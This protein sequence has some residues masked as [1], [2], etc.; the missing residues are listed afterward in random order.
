MAR[1]PLI[2]FLS[3][4]NGAEL[5]GRPRLRPLRPRVESV[6]NGFF[7]HRVQ[8]GD[9][10][11]AVL[12]HHRADAFQAHPFGKGIGAILVLRVLTVI[13]HEAAGV[14]QHLCLAVHRAQQVA[15]ITY[16]AVRLPAAT[17]L[18]MPALVTPLQLHTW[19]SGGISS[20]VT[21]CGGAPRSN[22]SDTRSSGSLLSRSKAPAS[23]RPVLLV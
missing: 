19:V 5:I 13:L 16:V 3:C 23:D 8:G 20:S 12:Q 18:P 21:F 1:S 7:Q 22:S 14:L 4:Q 2:S 17:P 11:V 10:P 9:D 15:F 6:G